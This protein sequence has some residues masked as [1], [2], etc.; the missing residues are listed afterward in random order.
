[1]REAAPILVP[2]A[3]DAA[4][5]NRTAVPPLTQEQA[6]RG[7]PMRHFAAVGAKEGLAPGL[8]VIS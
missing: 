7:P 2:G 8:T 4:G 5:P 3:P 1:M 6:G